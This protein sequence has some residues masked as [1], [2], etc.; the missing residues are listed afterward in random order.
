MILP[1]KN[2]LRRIRLIFIMWSN[3]VIIFL[4]WMRTVNGGFIDPDTP[5]EGYSTK[6]YT[7]GD[8]RDYELVS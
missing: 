4:I 3:G 6:S 5:K 1:R 2:D 8:D 7:I